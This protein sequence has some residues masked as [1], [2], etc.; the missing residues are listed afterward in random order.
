MKWYKERMWTDCWAGLDNKKKKGKDIVEAVKDLSVVDNAADI[1]R[2]AKTNKNVDVIKEFA[3][4]NAKKESNFVV[5]GHV[6]AGKSTLMGRLLYDLKVVDERTIQKFKSESEK[7]GK[8]SF[9]YAWVLDQTEEERARGVT[10]DI[11]QNSFET[12][13]AKFT[14][15]DAPG[16]RDFIPNM[17]A[18]SSQADFAVLVIDSS[19]GAFEAGFH[20][21]GQTKEHTLLVRSIGIQ[22]IIVAVNKLDSVSWAEERFEEIRQQMTVFLTS[23]GFHAKNISFVPCSGLTGENV[24]TPLKPSKAPWY[25]GSSLITELENSSP[26]A[27]AIDKPLRLTVADVF[28]GG[29]QNPV[30]ISGRIDS[31]TLQVGDVL[32]ALPSGEKTAVKAIEINNDPRPWAV[33]GHNCTIHLAGIDMLHL[34]QG[35]VLSSVSNPIPVVKEFTAKVLAFQTITPMAVDIHRGRLHVPGK[36]THLVR[37]LDKATGEE[38]KKKPRFIGPGTAAQVKVSLEQGV[39]LERGGRVVFRFGGV[40]VGSGVVE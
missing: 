36:I 40:T 32:L 17:I 35:D 15:L 12:D 11:A 8:A 18:G 10:M 22:R 7:I 1:E 27:R 14:I 19:T 9:Q 37:T 23:A 30:S 31:G 38:V 33:A 26:L 3:A 4:G 16:H 39:P 6:D 5:V 2:T 28:R 34:K 24:V 20:L 25:K 29:I 13:K 21:Q